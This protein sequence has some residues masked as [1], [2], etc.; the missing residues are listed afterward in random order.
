MGRNSGGVKA[1]GVGSSSYD[2]VTDALYA[3]IGAKSKSGVTKATKRIESLIGKMP[4][5]V[6]RTRTLSTS[7]AVYYSSR[8]SSPK[9]NYNPTIYNYN[10]TLN[11]LYRKEA[12]KRKLI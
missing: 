1:G 8:K 6:V 7:D 11:R 2:K 12:K 3:A 9:G 5:D 4:D 10:K